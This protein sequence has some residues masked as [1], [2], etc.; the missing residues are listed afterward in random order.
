MLAALFPTAYRLPTSLVL[1]NIVVLYWAVLLDILL[2]QY[3][4]LFIRYS[5][6]DYYVLDGQPLNI[7]DIHFCFLHNSTD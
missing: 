2:T 1:G 5:I 4:L 3:L 7:V 6:L